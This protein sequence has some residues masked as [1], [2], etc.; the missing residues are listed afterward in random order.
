V[1]SRSKVNT[2]GWGEGK[3]KERGLPKEVTFKFRGGNPNRPPGLV[4]CREW[5]KGR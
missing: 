5:M 4:L 2:T 3:A 1:E